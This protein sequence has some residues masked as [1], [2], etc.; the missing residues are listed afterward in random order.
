MPV[1]LL[2]IS[3]NGELLASS[4]A[5]RG[6]DTTGAELGSQYLKLWNVATGELVRQFAEATDAITDIRFS[7]DGTLLLTGQRD[8][9]VRLWSIPEGAVVRDLATGWQHIEGAMSNFTGKSVAFSPDGKL[10]AS[11]GVDWTITEAHTGSISLWS[12]QDGSLKARL[13]SLVEANLGSIEWSPDS[14]MFAAGTNSG[15]RIWCL[16]ELASAPTVMPPPSRTA[17]P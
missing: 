10:A 14:K 13:L 17:Q 4:G 1:G 9:L 16:D 12:V 15:A 8:G 11:A 6:T 2:A 7:P 3:P 5:E